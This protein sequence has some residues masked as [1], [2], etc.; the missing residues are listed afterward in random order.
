[1]RCPKCGCEES[2][3]VD[4]RPSESNDAI[5]RRRECVRCGYRFTTYERREEMPLLVVKKDGR[6]ET[7]DRQKLMRGLLTATVKRSV[8]VE[9]LDGLIDDIESELRDEGVNEVASHDLGSMVL[10]RLVNVDKVAYIRFASVYRDFKDVDEFSE[11][12]RSLNK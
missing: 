10:K 8:P 1:M 9:T 7:F 4:S 11:E 6:K 12:L 3:V 2:K 5:R